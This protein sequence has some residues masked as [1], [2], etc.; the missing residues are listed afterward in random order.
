MDIVETRE[1]ETA[2]VALVGALDTSSSPALTAKAFAL[3]GTG[4]R[5]LVVDLDRVPHLTS[6]GFRAFI[7]IKRRCATGAIQM[8][9]CGCND[10][11]REMFEI[12][13]M[14]G[15]FRIVADREA[16]LQAD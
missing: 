6:A 1:G 15:T 8:T 2:I 7:A 13:G 4:I 10:L 14:L 9:L 3:C 12:G 16:A 5:A 11:V